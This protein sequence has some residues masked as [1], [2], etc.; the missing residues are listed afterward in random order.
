VAK[1]KS[2]RAAGESDIPAPVTL[3]TLRDHLEILTRAIFQAGLSWALIA[4]RWPIFEP[5]FDYF[6]VLRVANY[7]DFDTERLMATDG[8]IHSVKKIRGTITNA[9]ALIELERDFGS[10]D[11]YAQRFAAYADLFADARGRFAFL[12]DLSCYYW[13]FRTGCP[14]PPFETWIAAQPK[15]HPR[16]RELVRAARHAGASSERAGF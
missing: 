3:P 14:V 9:N 10:V 16:M 4:A 13:L 12:G 8:L 15:D 1:T 7:G 5:A 11:G 2:L 6:D